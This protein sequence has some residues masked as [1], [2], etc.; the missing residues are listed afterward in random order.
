MDYS[1]NPNVGWICPRCNK[2]NAPTVKQ[3]DCQPE[4]KPRKRNWDAYDANPYD[5]GS[6]R[7]WLNSDNTDGR[8]SMVD[9][10]F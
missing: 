9:G 10:T 2:V 5:S 8:W 1:R 7:R 3:C 6:S 4:D